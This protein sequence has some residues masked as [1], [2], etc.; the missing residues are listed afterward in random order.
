[1]TEEDARAYQRAAPE[2]KTI[3]WY[4]LGHGLGMPAK[5][6]ELSW[7]HETVGTA[8]P[9]RPETWWCQEEDC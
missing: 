8:P 2:P 6:D 3:K 4:D 5:I 1:M 7:L 9:G